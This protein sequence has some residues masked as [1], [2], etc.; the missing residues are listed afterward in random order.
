MISAI[1]P[2]QQEKPAILLSLSLK[3]SYNTSKSGVKGSVSYKGKLTLGLEWNKTEFKQKDE[4]INLE[5]INKF[6]K[7]TAAY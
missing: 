7:S 3:R 5:E 4:L 1:I 6:R 2:I